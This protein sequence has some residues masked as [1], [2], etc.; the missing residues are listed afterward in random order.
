MHLQYILAR[1]QAVTG[2]TMRECAAKMALRALDTRLPATAQDSLPIRLEMYTT[3]IILKDQLSTT[4]TQTE[5]RCRR[6]Q[7][8]AHFSIT[9]TVQA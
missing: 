7:Q 6:C 4:V 8:E 9:A 2:Q 5:R 1:T 3:N